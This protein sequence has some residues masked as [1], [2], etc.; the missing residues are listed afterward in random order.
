MKARCPSVGKHQAREVVKSEW[1]ENHP[2][3][4]RRRRDRIGGFWRGN[5]GFHF[6][7]GDRG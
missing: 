2:Y 6:Q 4:S 1:V 5:Q 3:R 7:S